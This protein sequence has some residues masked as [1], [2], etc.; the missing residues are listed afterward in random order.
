MPAPTPPTEPLP[1]PPPQPVSSATV[2][3]GPMISPI[4]RLKLFNPT[5]WEEFIVEWTETLRPSYVDVA[6]L[7][8]SGDQ[9]RDVI[10]IS[11]DGSWDSYQCKHYAQP[12]APHEVW[13]E[14]G[15]LV[16]YTY[17]G[18]F[19]CPRRYFFLAPQGVGTALSNLLRDPD[20]LQ[21]GLLD[22]W[23]VHCEKKITAT[24]NVVLDKGLRGH[25]ASFD[26]AIFGTIAPHR[27]IDG[28]ATT[29]WHVAR[30]GGGLPPRPA[31]DLPPAQPTTSETPYVRALLAAY[32]DHLKQPVESH[33]QLPDGS[34]L[35]GHFADAR[36]EFYSAEALRAFSRDT[37]PP[38]SFEDLQDQIHSGIGD[39]MRGD[40][41]DGY[42]RVLAVV[43]TARTLALDGH[44][45]NTSMTTRDRGGVCHQL[46]NGGTIE[47]WVK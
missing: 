36:R 12:L 34:P 2:A 35:A 11:E 25:I 8:G 33:E 19:A 7:G 42:R 32:A 14:I 13:T 29:R 16:H 47:T 17:V 20:R 44:A 4:D 6:R 24:A 3:A 41:T 27:L 21:T 37:L 38:G 1:E 28:H 22:N 39:D 18:K 10:G 23:A 31:P 9:G 15:K 43:A 40:H 45:L 26:F 5:E 30:F 46:A